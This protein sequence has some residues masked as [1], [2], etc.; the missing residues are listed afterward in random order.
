MSMRISS[1][2]MEFP[3]IFTR[4][5]ILQNLA[6]KKN[7]LTSRPCYHISRI[8]RYLNDE[9]YHLQIK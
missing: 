9:K 4:H 5:E 3:H 6:R 8:Y 7:V 1:F 2:L